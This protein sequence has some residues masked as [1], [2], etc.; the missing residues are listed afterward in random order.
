MFTQEL[1]TTV[2]PVEVS[3]SKD[4]GHP[5]EFWAK[6]AVDRIICIE[7]SVS[8]VISE[9]AR[10]FRAQIE[11]VILQSMVRAIACDRG[12]VGLMLTEAGYPQ[13]AEIIRRP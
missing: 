10:A 6:R 7:N 5:P 2:F 12:K 3:V 1:Q 11:H 4:G 13:L 9:Q 8:P